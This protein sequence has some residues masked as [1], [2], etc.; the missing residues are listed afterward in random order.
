V[1]GGSDAGK[2][3]GVSGGKLED[4]SSPLV[5]NGEG[6]SVRLKGG[7]VRNAVS[8][9]LSSSLMARVNKP[10]RQRAGD[11]RWALPVCEGE[12]TKRE[13]SSVQPCASLLTVKSLPLIRSSKPRN[14]Q[15]AHI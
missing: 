11:R 4:A 8:N 3:V 6:G 2:S 7:R 14:R 5:E 12:S 15:N 9:P 13:S 10:Q 1:W